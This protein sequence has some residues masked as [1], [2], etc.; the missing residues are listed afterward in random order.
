MNGGVG[1]RA[2]TQIREGGYAPG[3]G[4]VRAGAMEGAG[5]GGRAAE[6]EC[7]RRVHAGDK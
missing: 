5:G 4:G 7:S 2:F 3:A 1:G 6:D